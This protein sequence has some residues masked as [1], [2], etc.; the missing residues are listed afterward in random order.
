MYLP[1]ES[2]RHA[3]DLHLPCE[4]AIGFEFYSTSM[5]YRKALSR[6]TGATFYGD[7]DFSLPPN[8]LSSIAKD[9]SV[10]PP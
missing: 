1:A 7:H 5:F 6:Q 2:I 10:Q 9:V 8:A 4:C 3:P